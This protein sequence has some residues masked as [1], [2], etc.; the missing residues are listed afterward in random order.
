MRDKVDFF[1]EA[2]LFAAVAVTG[3]IV[4]IAVL[5][6]LGALF[7]YLISIVTGVPIPH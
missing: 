4:V 3:S 2:F 7:F 1:A 5:F 6:G